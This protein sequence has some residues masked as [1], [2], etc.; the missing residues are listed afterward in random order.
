MITGLAKIATDF[1]LKYGVIDSEDSEIYQYGNE[2]IISS[3]LDLIIVFVMGV[4]FSALTNSLLFF[5]TFLLLRSFSGGYH[6]DSY[7]KCK[8]IFI[9]NLALMLFLLANVDRLYQINFMVLVL[10][11]SILIVWKLAPIENEGKPLSE[12]DIRINSKRSKII[13]IIL[14]IIIVTT[15]VFNRNVSL[16]LLLS[17]F[18][19]SVGMIIEFFRKGGLYNENSNKTGKQ[20][21]KDKS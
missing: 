13:S 10:F 1:F 15:Y 5:A 20:D 3:I 11:F 6:A 2:I 14:S 7:W 19:V 9:I 4:I 17:F 18:S 16:S 21:G 12:E 8:I